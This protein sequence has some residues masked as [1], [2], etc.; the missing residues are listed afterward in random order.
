MMIVTLMIV[1]SVH[2]S[3]CDYD[4]IQRDNA[5]AAAFPAPSLR[6]R[7]CRRLRSAC[8][9]A[10]VVLPPSL[11]LRT[12]PA[13]L[14]PLTPSL[15]LLLSSLPLPSSFPYASPL[16]IPSF[17]SLLPLSSPS[18]PPSLPIS[19]ISN[20]SLSCH[21]ISFGSHFLSFLCSFQTFLRRPSFSLPPFSY[22][23]LSSFFSFESFAANARFSSHFVPPFRLS[24]FFRHSFS[25]A[26]FP[27]VLL[28]YLFR[29]SDPRRPSRPLFSGPPLSR[30]PPLPRPPTLPPALRLRVILSTSN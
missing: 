14:L 2:A 27:L 9:R 1:I 7:S 16:V 6:R 3:S 26:S 5:S 22:L 28:T 21:F 18:C 24:S 12:S 25:P 4:F 17:L 11:F 13:A 8:F 15:L 10:R 30:P 29:T 23:F 20:S 19:L